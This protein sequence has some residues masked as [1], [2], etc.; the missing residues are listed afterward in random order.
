MSR[1]TLPPVNP[2]KSLAGITVDPKT[3]ER[4]IPESRRPDGSV[5]KQLKVRP[6]FTPQEDV[7]RFRSTKQA[8]IEANQL[9]KGHIVGWVPPPNAAKPKPAGEGSKAAVSKTAAKNAKRKEK[10]KAQKEQEHLEKIRD[11]WESSEDEA[12]EASKSTDGARGK[13]PEAGAHTGD[14]PE[15][16]AA[17]AAGT[18]DA[19][20]LSEKLEKLNVKS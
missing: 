2:E 18:S 10:K 7:K 9:P 20:G 16:A 14:K 19:D 5:R 1:T 8:Q 4:V 15:S 11:N 6:G 13:E 12:P 17:P 3:L